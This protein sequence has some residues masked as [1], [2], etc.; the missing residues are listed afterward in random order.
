MF[1]SNRKHSH[2]IM[3]AD[4]IPHSNTGEYSLFPPD[5]TIDGLIAQLMVVCVIGLIFNQHLFFKQHFLL[6]CLLIVYIYFVHV[7]WLA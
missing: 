1:I 3:L 2:V 4:N 7:G 6:T 5:V